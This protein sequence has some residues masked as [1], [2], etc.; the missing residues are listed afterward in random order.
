VGDLDGILELVGDELH[1]EGI[2]RHQDDL[3]DLAALDAH[4]VLRSSG[5]DGGLVHEFSAHSVSP[6]GFRFVDRGAADGR[7]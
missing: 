2:A 5:A 4:V 6:V 3:A 7:P 1:A